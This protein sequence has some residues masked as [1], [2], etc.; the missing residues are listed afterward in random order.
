[1][2]DDLSTNTKLVVKDNALIEASFNLSLVEQRLMLL[3]IVEAREIPNLSIDTPIKVSVKSYIE[4]FNVSESSAYTRIQD[5][6][7]T[8]FN[9]QF[10][11]YDSAMDERFRERWLYKAS[12]MDD[13]GHV[14][15]YFTPTVIQMISRLEAQFTKYMLI[16]VS[17]F[18]SKYSIRLYEII[19]K[20]EEV[21]YTYK[22][23][24]SDL[25]AMLG[26]E[27]HEYK[28][29]SLFKVNVLDKALKEINSSSTI[30]YTVK[31][32]QIK[33]GV[34]ITHLVFK[35]RR[36]PKYK[37]IVKDAET[38][39]IFTNMTDK[40]AH[41]FGDKLARNTKFQSHFK[42]NTGESIDD[43][44]QRIKD[45]LKDSFYVEQWIKYLEE[46]GYSPTKKRKGA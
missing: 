13:K 3:G 18:K 7:T 45:K 34:R 23:S 42:A 8:L 40:Q 41:M 30:P 44:A 33:E 15:M 17:N 36:K 26:V 35:L 22:Y 37:A 11:Y 43:Y 24:V 2:S 1:M 10:S 6:L 14:I 27:D 32:E 20:W 5:A 16:N 46:E 29:M 4:Q 19:A 25:R 12:Y 38:I 21:G 39:D 28:T 31:Y 9:R